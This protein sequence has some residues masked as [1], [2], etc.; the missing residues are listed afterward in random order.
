MSD[1]LHYYK[2]RLIKQKVLNKRLKVVAAMTEEKKR[3]KKCTKLG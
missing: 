1:K 2:G 3:Q